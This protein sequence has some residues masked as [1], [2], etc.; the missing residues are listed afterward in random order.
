MRENDVLI[1]LGR[2]LHQIFL[3]EAASVV[4]MGLEKLI[5][6]WISGESRPNCKAAL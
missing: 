5:F 6:Q 1:Q 3:S 4:S 2:R